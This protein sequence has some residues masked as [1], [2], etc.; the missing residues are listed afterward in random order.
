MALLIAAAPSLFLQY[1]APTDLPLCYVSTA[2]VLPVVSYCSMRW[3]TRAGLRPL[4][5]INLGVLLTGLLV[6]RALFSL[7]MDRWVAAALITWVEVQAF[8][9]AL[10]FETLVGSLF[11]LR[12]AKTIFPLV[13][14]GEVIAGI[15]GGLLV[16]LVAPRLGAHNLLLLGVGA[17]TLAIGVVLLLKPQGAAL[18][19]GAN[20][21]GE[22]NSARA[23]LGKLAFAVIGTAALADMASLIGDNLYY[24]RLE[25]HFTSADQMAGFI[26]KYLATAGVASLLMRLFVTPRL[27]QRFGLGVGLA[28]GPLLGSVFGVGL[29]WTTLGEPAWEWLPF[30]LAVGF[31]FND[32]VHRRSNHRT[33]LFL[34]LQALPI[35]ERVRTLALM[36]GVF[37]AAVGGLTGLLLLALNE[38]RPAAVPWLLVGG[39]VLWGWGAWRIGRTYVTALSEGLRKRLVFLDSEAEGDSVKAKL[40]QDYLK[41]HDPALVLYSLCRLG[42]SDIPAADLR[43][44]LA[45]QEPEIRMEAARCVSSGARG[46]EF[47]LIK[48]RVAEETDPIVLA[49]LLEAGLRLDPS[50]G[51]ELARPSF[52]SKEKIV[53][54]AAL[55][56]VLRAGQA[57]DEAAH[58]LTE[59]A[60][61]PDPAQRRTAAE[62]IGAAAFAPAERQL[63]ALLGDEVLEVRCAAVTAA[64]E[65]KTTSLT[66]H[67]LRLLD[68]EECQ[69]EVI[70]ALTAH[71]E[72]AARLLESALTNGR[73]SLSAR[74]AAIRVLGRLG[75][76][77]LLWERLATG[78]LEERTV[79]LESLL[80]TLSGSAAGRAGLLSRLITEEA[81]RAFVG[82]SLLVHLTNHAPGSLL[83]RSLVTDCRAS[84]QRLVNTLSIAYTSP[85]F[86]VA[87]PHLLDGSG[88]QLAHAMEMVDQ[89]LSPE[90][91]NRLALSMATHSSQVETCLQ[92]EDELTRALVSANEEAAS[93][94]SPIT[95]ILAL[96][97]LRERRAALPAVLEYVEA[98][99]IADTLSTDP[100]IGMTGPEEL[101]EVLARLPFASAVD[102]FSTLPLPALVKVTRRLRPV[103]FPAGAHLMREGEAGEKLFILTQGQV[104]VHRSEEN[105]AVL[106]PGSVIG[107]MAVLS[108]APR[109]A[110]VTAETPVAVFEMDRD[111]LMGLTRQHFG[112]TLSLTRMLARRLRHA[113][114]QKPAAN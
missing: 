60:A 114:R 98:Q 88:T 26:G 7:G 46:G 91:R 4:L 103:R 30:W 63:L 78:P 113:L 33:G 101:E 81:Q 22:D 18:D 69:T 21:P 66:Q 62:V 68:S 49:A 95:R 13:G 102:C 59:W 35:P 109:V 3:S 89:V 16:P 96:R 29:A 45:H 75:A 40:L 71:D 54:V 84:R 28:L 17:L 112:L 34:I 94:L 61:S 19:A 43:R 77:D 2:V 73:L 25:S 48:E 8:L 5:F 37:G 111:T 105:I 42:E 51:T 12:R 76:V 90:D 24:A 82:Q 53:R 65:V 99:W 6:L 47:Q 55:A 67:L 50:A 87:K 32:D 58:V 74:L 52:G 14:T 11:D 72:P 9:L 93:A 41:S 64:G 44:L 38:F 36:D 23:P 108:P 20:G 107:E 104:R 10:E 70:A 1:F 85:V 100:F 110:S 15:A 56:G 92:I 27:Y 31:K 106:G 83:L 39:I 80:G 97:W 79:L 86:E 57:A